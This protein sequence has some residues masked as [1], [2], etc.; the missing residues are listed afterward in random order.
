MDASLALGIA[1]FLGFIFS[2]VVHECAHVLVAAWCGDDTAWLLGRFTLNPIP[3]IDPFWSILVPVALWVG[4]APVFG[5]AKPVPVDMNN[6]RGHRLIAMM[7]V[8]L[9]GPISNVLLALAFAVFLNFIPWLAHQD[10]GLGE[11]LGTILCGLVYTNLLLAMFNLIPIPPLDG[12]RILAAALPRPWGWYVYQYERYGMILVA[13]LVFSGGASGL[14]SNWVSRAAWGLLD[15]TVFA[16]W[17]PY[18]ERLVALY[19]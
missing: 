14:L 10:A 3:H 4:G 11:K 6:L 2:I 8:A 5:G 9:A 16:D 1:I 17:K 13:I 19:R 7:W 15:L 18:W 12:S